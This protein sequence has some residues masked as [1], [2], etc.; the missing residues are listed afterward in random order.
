MTRT[1][2]LPVLALLPLAALAACG[3]SGSSSSSPSKSASP[4]ATSMSGTE[5]FKGSQTGK[6]A[7]ATTT[8]IPL[9]YSGPVTTTGTFNGGGPSP[10]EGQHHTFQTADGKFVLVV[11]GKPTTVQHASAS[12][13][14]FSQ[15]ITVPYT[16]DGAA[17]TGKFA[18]ATGSGKVV[19]T[20]GAY[21]PKLSN[22]KCNT[23]N[24]AQPLAKGAYDTFLGSG[25]LT[26][27]G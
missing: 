27:K 15:V 3:S 19:V 4:A 1:R 23:S 9:T 25:P 18:G 20:F 16:V 5:T 24:N 6:A 12:T 14:Y 10:A 21:G 11:S 13:C 2:I 7:V 17:S 26:V 8:A 22:G